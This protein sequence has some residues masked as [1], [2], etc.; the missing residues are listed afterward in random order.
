VIPELG[1]DEKG[2]YDRML[3]I[4]K[5]RFVDIENYIFNSGMLFVEKDIDDN[6]SGIVNVQDDEEVTDIVNDL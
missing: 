6:S 5:E 3:Q 4:L 2:K 1:I